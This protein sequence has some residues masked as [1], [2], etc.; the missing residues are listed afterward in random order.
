MQSGLPVPGLGWSE[1]RCHEGR[2]QPQVQGAATFQLLAGQRT[3]TLLA[4]VSFS[5]K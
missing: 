2:H 5:I 3:A 1:G 4:S